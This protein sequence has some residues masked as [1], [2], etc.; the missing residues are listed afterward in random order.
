MP[1]LEEEQMRQME[2][3]VDFSWFVAV[4]VGKL[5]IERSDNDWLTVGHVDSDNSWGCRVTARQIRF[6]QDG[7]FAYP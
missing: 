4:F 2:G 5:N 6:L 7:Q 3:R 1:F